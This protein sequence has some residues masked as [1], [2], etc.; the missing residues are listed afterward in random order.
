[1]AAGGRNDNEVAIM[2]DALKRGGYDTTIRVIPREQITDLQMRAMLP[3]ILDA[4][5]LRAFNPPTEQ[6]PRPRRFSTCVCAVSAIGPML[7]KLPPS[8]L[9]FPR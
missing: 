5:Y 6:L 1:M 3:G 4:S 9:P 2:A 8:S 7:R